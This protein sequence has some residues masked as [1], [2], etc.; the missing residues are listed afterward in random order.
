MSKLAY[1]YLLQDGQDKNTNIYKIGRTVQDGTD[2]RKLRR[3]Q[4]YSKDTVVFNTFHVQPQMVNSIESKIKQKLHETCR[5]VRGTE[6]FEGDV[7]SMKKVID[8]IIEK[9]ESV[10][11]E[12][13]GEM[14][15]NPLECA[16]CNTI[17]ASTTL[18][19]KHIQ[20]CHKT[21]LALLQEREMLKPQPTKINKAIYQINCL[22]KENIDYLQNNEFMI[23]CINEKDGI[24][25]YLISKHFDPQHPENH[26]LKKLI[27][28]DKFMQ[29]YVEDIMLQDNITTP[30]TARRWKLKF[31]YDVMNEVF[32]NMEVAFADFV[33]V[34]MK[35]SQLDKISIDNFMKTVGAPL[36][37]DIDCDDY[38]FEGKITHDKR[39][40][41][42]KRIFD[43]AI[44]Y[45]YRNSKNR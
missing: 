26:N 30:E 8:Q 36:D 3:L 31:S 6:W 45:I 34:N 35:E 38:K 16:K 10:D 9:N 5:L 43:L 39:K 4:D 28:M 1:I 7:K 40:V 25:E 2:S 17:Y 41:L 18:L 22:G 27:K 33:D 20:I 11:N 15:V 32:D 37:W 29:S 21:K 42:R 24:F 13:L 44:E 12:I 23:S 14:K 19:C